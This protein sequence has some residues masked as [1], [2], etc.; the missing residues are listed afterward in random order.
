MNSY[1]MELTLCTSS[2]L[3]SLSN[4]SFHENYLDVLPC[5]EYIVGTFYK[6]HITNAIVRNTILP[7]IENKYN[8]LFNSQT[9]LLVKIDD[10]IYNAKLFRNGKIIVTGYKY[11][12]HDILH[13]IVD[14][15]I[16]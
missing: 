11:E 13:I 7:N 1:K 14:R 2:I 3:C 5:T 8:R 12:S 4:I 10:E 9:T 6:H 16:D 15:I